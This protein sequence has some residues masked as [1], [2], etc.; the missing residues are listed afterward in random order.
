MIPRG[1]RWVSDRRAGT[2]AGSSCFPRACRGAL[3]PRCLSFRDDTRRCS[4]PGALVLPSV[5]DLL[6]DG[7]R[8]A[9][10]V[11]APRAAIGGRLR[12]HLPASIRDLP[13]RPILLQAGGAQRQSACLASRRSAFGCRRIASSEL[14]SVL[15]GAIAPLPVPSL[16]CRAIIGRADSLS[17]SVD[18]EQFG[19][20]ALRAAPARSASLAASRSEDRFASRAATR[21][22]S[23]ASFA[24]AASPAE[25]RRRS[26]VVVP[27]LIKEPR[28]PLGE[29][30]GHFPFTPTLLGEP[31]YERLALHLGGL[32][33]RL[34]REPL[35]AVL[36]ASGILPR[37]LAILLLA[38]RKRLLTTRLFARLLPLVLLSRERHRRL[39]PAAA[40]IEPPGP[41]ASEDGLPGR[42]SWRPGGPERCDVDGH[43][44][45]ATCGAYC[46]I[47]TT[48]GAFVASIV[49]NR[50]M[51]RAGG[52]T[53]LRVVP[54]EA[55]TFRRIRVLRRRLVVDV[56]RKRRRHRTRAEQ[57]ARAGLG[58]DL[59]RRPELE[60][61]G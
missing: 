21:S 9:L 44:A 35:P 57:E 28:A 34:E 1:R 42:P 23:T 29:A 60:L 56:R 46:W 52:G 11:A 25:A 17:G 61:G 53:G 38:T 45:R 51:S 36:L 26:L 22:V 54:Q 32:Q 58:R 19:C 43:G 40:Q 48:G 13:R 16:G 39:P 15:P 50:G 55:G 12:A 14:G 4:T 10:L 33:L 7:L 3:P 6:R 49:M 31:R 20:S 37:A 59:E 30:S 2:V 41:A 8:K 5:G 24:R 18:T 27:D 47:V